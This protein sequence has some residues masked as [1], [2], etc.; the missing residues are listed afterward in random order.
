[1]IRLRTLI[2]KLF[3]IKGHPIRTI[4]VAILCVFLFFDIISVI[5]STFHS[6]F[7]I[8][9]TNPEIVID[10]TGAA[11]IRITIHNKTYRG[12]IVKVDLY[13]NYYELDSVR[14]SLEPERCDIARNDSL[15]FQFHISDNVSPH[16]KS[17]YGIANKYIVVR[18]SNGDVIYYGESSDIAHIYRASDTQLK[19]LDIEIEDNSFRF[20]GKGIN[21]EE[22]FD[23]CSVEVT[24]DNLYQL[25]REYNVEW[26]PSADLYKVYP[27]ALY[28][29]SAYF[30]RLLKFENGKQV[31]SATYYGWN[32]PYIFAQGDGY[33][34]AFNSLSTTSGFNT[35]TFTAKTVLLDSNLNTLKEREFRFKEQKDSYYAYVYIDTLVQK[36]DGYDFVVINTG[37]DADDYYEYK[38]HLSKDNVVTSSSKRNVKIVQ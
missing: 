12:N 16:I 18:F 23:D 2:R 30:T 32:V 29:T 24:K 5:I 8:K 17:G 3:D 35:S 1:M 6:L 14:V 10:K 38:G 7:P 37:F 21:R 27:E 28:T 9:A 13:D 15:R 36:S 4:F 33:F 25:Y 31:A 11:Y 19:N 22:N 34:A 26:I 20:L